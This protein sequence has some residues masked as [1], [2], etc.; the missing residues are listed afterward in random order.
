MPIFITSPIIAD[1]DAEN[2]FKALN[3]YGLIY[4]FVEI[5]KNELYL[6]FIPEDDDIS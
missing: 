3:E 5:R 2:I 6:I 4:N 1:L